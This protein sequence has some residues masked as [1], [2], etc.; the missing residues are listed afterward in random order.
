MEFPSTTV[1]IA[2]AVLSALP[3]AAQI[4][5]YPADSVASI[6]VNYTEALAGTYT[7][8]DPLVLANGKPVRDAKSWY[9]K[10]RPE[11][12]RLFE[13]NEYGRSP[14]RP[15]GSIPN[16]MAKERCGNSG[17]H[18]RDLHDFARVGLRQWRPILGKIHPARSQRRFHQGKADRHQRCRAALCRFDQL[19][20]R[21]Q[22][23]GV[24]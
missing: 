13:E 1:L 9:E 20:R 16:P 21:A 14:G 18:R 17:R 3:G 5:D 12:V 11:I 24:S 8:P 2:A 15:A 23:A 7:L 19:C 10:R 22:S 4:A 6:P